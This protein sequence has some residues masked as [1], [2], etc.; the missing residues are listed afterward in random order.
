MCS[1]SSAPK[2]KAAPLGGGS[3]GG[4]GGGGGGGEGKGE[5]KK[6]DYYLLLDVPAYNP[7]K[8]DGKVNAG[9][10]IWKAG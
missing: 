1:L 8:S 6:T 5:A 4:G 3:G 2:K 7:P 9:G 10:G